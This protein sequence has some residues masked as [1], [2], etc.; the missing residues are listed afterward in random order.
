ML[1]IELLYDPAVPLLDV[2]SGGT[3]TC[4]CLKTETGMFTA[5]PF[6]IK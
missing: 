5:A 6:M 3:K 2:H 4:V 1:S